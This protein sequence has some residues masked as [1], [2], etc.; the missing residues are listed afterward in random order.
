MVSV[1]PGDYLILMRKKVKSY[2]PAI[3]DAGFERKD[4]VIYH[5]FESGTNIEFPKDDS[6]VLLLFESGSGIHR[7]DNTDHEI[8]PRQVQMVSP[9]QVHH[10]EF[11]PEIKGKE[12]IINRALT[13]TFSSKLQFSFTQFIQH[14]VLNLD[15]KTFKQLNAEFLS[16]KTELGSTSVFTELINAR[17]RLITLMI[18]LWAKDKFGDVVTYQ[19]NPLSFKFHS[20]VEHHYRTQKSVSFYANHLCITPNYLGIICRKQ[21]HMSALEMIQER[22]LLEAKRLLHSSAMSIKE[23]AFHLGFKN[24]VYFSYFFKTKTTLTPSEYRSLMQNC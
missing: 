1:T 19:S 6:F 22:V 23:I 7:I 20:L 4:Y 8:K 11:G 9:G 5:E 3:K 16:I 13:E 21:F 17:C 18:T 24:L 12:L 14:A 10:W 15:S 2:L